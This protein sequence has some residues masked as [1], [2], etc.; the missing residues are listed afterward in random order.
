MINL[1]VEDLTLSPLS[2]YIYIYVLLEAT[3]EGVF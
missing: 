2:L 1:K 3:H